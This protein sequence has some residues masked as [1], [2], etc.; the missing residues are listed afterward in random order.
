MKKN[1][2]FALLLAS[3]TASAALAGCQ[4]EPSTASEP[5]AESES[6]VSAPAS[7]PESSASSEQAEDGL[8]ELTAEQK[9][10]EFDYLCNFL[11]EAFPFWPDVEAAGIDKDAVYAQ[12]RES[13]PKTEDTLSYFNE[14]SSFLNALGGFGHLHTIDGYS[15]QDFQLF[16][17]SVD[18]DS[19]GTYNKILKKMLNNSLTVSTYS[20]LGTDSYGFYLKEDTEQPEAESRE[21]G[22]T[23]ESAE[24][25]LTWGAWTNGIAYIKIPS[26]L[27]EYYLSDGEELA[28]LLM[29]FRNSEN[30]IIDIR[31]NGGGSSFYW[32]DYLVQ[33][34]AKTNLVSE[35]YYLYRANDYTMDLAQAAGSALRDISEC[36]L[37]VDTGFFTHFVVD[38]ME[39]PA[40]ENPYQ[41]DIWLLVDEGVGSAAEEFVM[42]CQSSGFATV[43]G[44]RTYGDN[45]YGTPPPF[46]LPN[47]GL[48]FRMSLFYGLNADGSS[49]QLYGTK[50]DILVPV[51]EDPLDYCISVITG[52]VSV[53][54]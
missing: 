38:R 34:N 16:F 32:L 36:P 18:E 17:Q 13:I 14:M 8:P 15:Y 49:N 30:L 50:P 41:G 23:F 28:E 53:E 21:T 33:P 31:G 54:S 52:E 45:P 24:S 43:V 39:V 47:S 51:K 46:T 9:L 40:A 11:D 44:S 29:R 12:Y 7:A 37:P 19:L 3:L 48:L 20:C 4:S 27:P 6:S 1:R 10:E 25:Q 2:I 5:S 42:F 26:F 22:S 35:G